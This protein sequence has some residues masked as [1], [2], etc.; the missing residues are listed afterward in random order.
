MK[1]STIQ[2]LAIQKPLTNATIANRDTLKRSDVLE[3]TNG[4]SMDSDSILLLSLEFSR[5]YKIYN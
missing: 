3:F 2:V 4:E 1:V 5:E